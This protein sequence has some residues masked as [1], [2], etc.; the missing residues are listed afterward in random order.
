MACYHPIRGYWSRK[1]NYNGNHYITFNPRDGYEDRW[2]SVPC[3]RCPGCLL[4]R[5]FQWSVRCTVESYYHKESYFLTL[6]YSKENLPEDG[7]LNRAHFQSFMK[8]LRKHF[9]G[10]KLKVFYCGEYGDKRN[11]PH[12]HAIIF[13]LPLQ[14]KDYRLIPVGYSKK[15]YMNYSNP[16]ITRLWGKGLVTIGTFSS[17][18]ASYVAQYTLKKSKKNYFCKKAVKP[19][20]GM[21]R[22]PSIGFQ[23]F[24]EH[25]MDIFRRGYFNFKTKKD[26]LFVPFIRYYRKLFQRFQPSYYWYYF[27]RTIPYKFFKDAILRYSSPISYAKKLD[28][29]RL[30]ANIKEER[31]WR[32]YQVRLDL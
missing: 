30:N 7:C 18:A 15:G 13:G 12:Y 23:F 28:K 10:Y 22:R 2:I 17:D 1:K 31:F 16:H 20:I 6:T 25:L 26:N 11:R 24:K 32:R 3:G 19:F 29:E 21:S 5:S 14:Q 4:A 8:R 27:Q 9:S